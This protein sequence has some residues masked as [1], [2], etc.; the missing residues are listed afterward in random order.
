MYLNNSYLHKNNPQNSDGH[1]QRVLT[2]EPG[3]L[4]EDFLNNGIKIRVRVTGRSM[5][6]FLHGGEVLTIECVPCMSLKAGD[7]VLFRDSYGRPV[8]H[9]L[10]EKKLSPDGYGILRT[11]GD[12]L[13]A[14]D[15]P[16]RQDQVLGKVIRIDKSKHISGTGYIDMNLSR[17]RMINSTIAIINNM[18]AKVYCFMSRLFHIVPFVD[19]LRCWIRKLVSVAG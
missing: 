2:T 1:A 3:G 9:R 14:F 8:I 13:K 5:Y 15:R 4:V 10:M 11:K 19:R 12:S 17:W 16:V 18:R 6:P 7:L